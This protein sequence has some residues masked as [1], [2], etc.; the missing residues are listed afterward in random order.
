MGATSGKGRSGGP[1]PAVV[2]TGRSMRA[3]DVSRPRTAEQRKP[4]NKQSKQQDQQDQQDQDDG[5]G[6]S[7]PVS[8]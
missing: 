7:S 4:Q 1:T 8:S 3:R 5:K 6:G 2:G